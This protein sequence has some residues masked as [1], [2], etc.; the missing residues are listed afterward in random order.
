MGP[1]YSYLLEML[2]SLS[3]LLGFSENWLLLGSP[4]VAT[5]CRLPQF[6]GARLD[7]K[8]ISWP[9]CL[10][11]LSHWCSTS[12]TNHIMEHFGRQNSSQIDKKSV[13]NPYLS[14][15]KFQLQCLINFEQ[16]FISTPRLSNLQNH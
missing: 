5:T 12:F 3:I 9:I 14:S 6:P 13:K 7:R 4:H 16:I 2:F 1:R 8:T 10:P 15:I 11:L